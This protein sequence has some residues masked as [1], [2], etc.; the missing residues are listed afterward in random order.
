MSVCVFFF[1]FTGLKLLK[2]REGIQYSIGEERSVES[3]KRKFDDYCSVQEIPYE[4]NPFFT[5][6]QRAGVFPEQSSEELNGQ[7]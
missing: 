7:H 1:F 4:H 2:A 5:C 6:V 3:L